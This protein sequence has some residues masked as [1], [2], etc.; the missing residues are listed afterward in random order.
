MM[1]QA[2][3]VVMHGHLT[4]LIKEMLITEGTGSSSS[5]HIST[6]GLLRR[7][8]TTWGTCSSSIRCL[9]STSTGVVGTGTGTMVEQATRDGLATGTIQMALDSTT[10]RASS[11]YYKST[12]SIR[13]LVHYIVSIL[14]MYST[15]L[16]SN[17][18]NYRIFV[19]GAMNNARMRA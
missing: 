6:H 7:L 2:T 9:S 3:M 1:L 15:P 17:P 5:N 14:F 12:L 8:G 18:R 13:T 16:F 11:R 10:S 4:I 19:Y